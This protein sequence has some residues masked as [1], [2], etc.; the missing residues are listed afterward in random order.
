MSVAVA[1]QTYSLLVEKGF[2]RC[3][4]T[5]N[6]SVSHGGSPGYRVGI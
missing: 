5:G 1:R 4:G 2:G 6:N 3:R